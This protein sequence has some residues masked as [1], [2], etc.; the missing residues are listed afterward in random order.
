MLYYYSYDS[1]SHILEN[2][3]NW[4]WIFHR[5][6]I[7]HY[8]TVGK[9][10]YFCPN[11]HMCKQGLKL[12]FCHICHFNHDTNNIFWWLEKIY[13][14]QIF[15][16]LAIKQFLQL[17]L[18][19]LLN[20][21]NKKQKMPFEIRTNHCILITIQT[22]MLHVDVFFFLNLIVSCQH[23]K[24]KQN[25]LTSALW[26][27][28]KTCIKQ[29]QQTG[30][31]SLSDSRWRWWKSSDKRGKMPSKL[32]SSQFPS[33]IYSY[34]PPAQYLY[35]SSYKQWACSACTIFFFVRVCSF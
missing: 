27:Y 5:Y 9:L 1:N 8:S 30:W 10:Q 25:W 17:L 24:Q 3:N 20:L 21:F 14:P 22:M 4:K 18:L 7:W 34:K 32:L 35:F 6:I 28:A 33:E 26:N 31:I 19:Q 11:L 13:Q 15:F 23:L 2:K 12:P 29:N 16:F